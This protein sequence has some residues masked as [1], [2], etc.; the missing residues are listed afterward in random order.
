LERKDVLVSAPDL[1]GQRD[2]EEKIQNMF[3]ARE[4]TPLPV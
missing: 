3:A 1:D 2:Y 4:R